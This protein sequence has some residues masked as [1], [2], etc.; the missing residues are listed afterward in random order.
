MER[1]DQLMDESQVKHDIA[2][3]DQKS[4][5]KVISDISAGGR[6]L[7]A[8]NMLQHRNFLK[9]LDQ[10]TKDAERVV[11]DI[12]KQ[13]NFAH[14]GLKQAFVEKKTYELI[15]RRRDTLNKEKLNRCQLTET[16]DAELNR[17]QR[18]GSV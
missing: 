15:E 7:S 4:F 17:L 13:R 9:L 2:M 18:S 16:D 1:L 12:S 11:D 8:G 10:R 5:L 3:Q 6:A 14:E